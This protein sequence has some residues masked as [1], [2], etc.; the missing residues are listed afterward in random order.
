MV[1]FGFAAATL[2][3][4]GVVEVYIECPKPLL[5][6]GNQETCVDN[7]IIMFRKILLPPSEIWE[8]YYPFFGNPEK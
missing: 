2:A 8:P 5:V 6:L 3:Y 1:E 7:E 4:T